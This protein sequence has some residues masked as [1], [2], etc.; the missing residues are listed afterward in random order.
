[1]LMIS[2][3][4]T[5]ASD[6]GQF[7]LLLIAY[8]TYKSSKDKEEKDRENGTYD[9]LDSRFTEY[10]RL[11]ISHPKLPLVVEDDSTGSAALGNL[12]T[13]E[14]Y[15]LTC[16]Y[17]VLVSILERAFKL[18]T[19]NPTRG[20]AREKEWAGWEQYIA[21]Y[22]KFEPFRAFWLNATKNLTLSAG[23]H[24]DFEEFLKNKI[25]EAKTNANH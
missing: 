7:L 22:A 10:L 23:F 12:S 8:I 19:K 1:M 16:C 25:N 20:D 4:I 13:T 2:D 5:I 17:L 18:Y 24:R 21:D 9:S 3:T 11:A 14:K 15:Q 6:F